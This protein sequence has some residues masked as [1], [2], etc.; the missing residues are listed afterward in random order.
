MFWSSWQFGVD[1][2]GPV[3]WSKFVTKWTWVHGPWDIC[4]I[5]SPMDKNVHGLDMQASREHFKVVLT[6]WCNANELRRHLNFKP[7]SESCCHFRWTEKA[8]K[9][10]LRSLTSCCCSDTTQKWVQK[11]FKSPL[12]SLTLCCGGCMTWKWALEAYKCLL[13]LFPSPHH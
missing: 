8:F 3:H 4:A 9:Y 1:G 2:H 7:T 13:S 5:L 6:Q 12:C 11:T 10:L